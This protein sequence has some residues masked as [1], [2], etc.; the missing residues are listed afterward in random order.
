MIRGWGGRERERERESL[1]AHSPSSVFSYPGKQLHSND[2]MVLLHTLWGGQAPRSSHSL[3]S[4]G[5]REREGR[6]GEGGEGRGGEGWGY[7]ME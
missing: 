2:P 4:V 5:E 6:G 7:G 3:T 1:R